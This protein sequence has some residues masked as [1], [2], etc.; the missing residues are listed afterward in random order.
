MVTQPTNPEPEVMEPISV[1]VMEPVATEALQTIATAKAGIISLREICD[2]HLEG[3]V[4]TALKAGLNELRDAFDALSANVETLMELGEPVG[5]PTMAPFPEVMDAV[6][7][8]EDLGHE[9]RLMVVDWTLYQGIYPF[10]GEVT[11]PED[12]D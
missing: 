9:A 7:A 2:E 3:S 6:E 1:D 11:L 4:K 5:E 12:D 10:F 8:I